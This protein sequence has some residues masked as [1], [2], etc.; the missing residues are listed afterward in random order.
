MSSDFWLMSAWQSCGH[1][2]KPTDHTRSS[3]E[4]LEW[5]PRKCNQ[6]RNL[7][8]TLPC[9]W[10]LTCMDTFNAGV[11][12]WTSHP[13]FSSL[14]Q[15]QG[16]ICLTKFRNL[17]EH[18]QTCDIT[19]TDSGDLTSTIT[20]SQK[21]HADIDT[22]RQVGQIPPILSHCQVQKETVKI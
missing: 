5:T 3:L 1:N 12:T 20:G 17:S 15:V 8:Q 18:N 11:S 16:T 13:K 19:S 21:S 6:A 10:N 14:R 2:R 7:V 9:R 4:L 22:W